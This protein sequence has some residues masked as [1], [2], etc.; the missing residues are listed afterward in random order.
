MTTYAINPATAYA[1]CEQMDRITNAM[2]T[3]LANMGADVQKMLG[4][5][6]GSDAQAYARAK[7]EWEQAANVGM[8]NCLANARAALDSI[9]ENYVSTE[10]YGAQTWA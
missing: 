3:E 10:K 4:D 5:W 7:Q 1:T 9:V 8:P 6:Q 2:R